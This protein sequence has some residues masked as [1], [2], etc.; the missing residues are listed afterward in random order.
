[1]VVLGRIRVLAF[2]TH[3]FVL[4][5]YWA[6][7]LILSFQ[8]LIAVLMTIAWMMM[9]VMIIWD[10]VPTM[11]RVLTSIAIRHGHHLMLS[12]FERLCEVLLTYGF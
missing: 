8:V 5:L 10:M 11:R 3:V 9:T 12:C 4:L 1:M 2:T 7:Q 6:S